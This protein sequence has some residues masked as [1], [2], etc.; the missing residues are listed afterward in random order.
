MHL[1]I[2]LDTKNKYR[3]EFW[4]GNKLISHGNDGLENVEIRA[5]GKRTAVV[6]TLTN[7]NIVIKDSECPEIHRYHEI[8]ARFGNREQLNGLGL[9]CDMLK[10]SPTACDGCVYRPNKDEIRPVKTRSPGGQGKTSTKAVVG[11]R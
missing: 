2:K 7:V 4:L 11:L 9:I 10:V 5:V 6:L 1:V 8:Q 3:S